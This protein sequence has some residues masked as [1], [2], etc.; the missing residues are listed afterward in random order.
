MGVAERDRPAWPRRPEGTVLAVRAADPLGPARCWYLTVDGAGT[1]Y[2]FRRGEDGWQEDV[3]VTSAVT[4]A[5]VAA[6]APDVWIARPGMTLEVEVIDAEPPDV[7]PLLRIEQGPPEDPEAWPDDV[8]GRWSWDPDELLASAYPGLALIDRWI[9]INGRRVTVVDAGPAAK[10]RLVPMLV[11]AD[12]ESIET[13]RP[14]AEY[15]WYSEGGGPV[16][17]SGSHSVLALVDDLVVVSSRGDMGGDGRV[18]ALPR[19]VRARGAFF[20]DW[21][22]RVGSEGRAAVALEPLDP[23]QRLSPSEREEWEERLIDEDG[24]EFWFDLPADVED[25]LRSALARRSLAYRM[26]RNALR[27]PTGRLGRALAEIIGSSAVPGG[28]MTRL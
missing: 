19:G 12:G 1:L 20:A 16:S 2:A 5:E 15:R 25:A 6:V 14:M 4:A 11:A 27:R 13:F 24:S 17:F 28:R 10:Q 18:Q 26:V 23:D 22:L 21:A 8:A 3:Q 9:S 7:L